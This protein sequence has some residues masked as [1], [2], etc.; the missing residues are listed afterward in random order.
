MNSIILSLIPSW[1]CRVALMRKNTRKEYKRKCKLVEQLTGM[2]F[3]TYDK[4]MDLITAT[5]GAAL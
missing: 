1:Y 4:S 5:T 3:I 2:L